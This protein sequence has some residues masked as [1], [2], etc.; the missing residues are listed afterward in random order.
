[1]SI[2]ITNSILI[3]TRELEFQFSRSS[4]PGGQK[5]NKTSTKATLRWN[6]ELSP[7]ISSMTRNRLLEKLSSRLTTEG[8]IVI[9]SDKYRDRGR[10]TADCI[11]KFQELLRKALYRQKTRVATKPTRAS[12]KK[13]LDNKS[14]RSDLKKNRKKVDY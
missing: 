4:G 1:M 9:H 10:N 6:L 14:K 2:Q 7:S 8:E 11:V 5:V 3:P 12:K 13:R